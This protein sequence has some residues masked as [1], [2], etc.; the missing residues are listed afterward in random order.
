MQWTT[1]AT[2]T[3][4]CSAGVQ[5]AVCSVQSGPPGTQGSQVSGSQAV[6]CTL[7]HR[8]EGLGSGPASS[9]P[10]GPS[11]TYVPVLRWA[12]ASQKRLSSY[13]C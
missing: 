11:P 13:P 10:I 6:W 2:A 3:L 7:D 8:S 5:C 4:L 12:Q 9:A 1:D